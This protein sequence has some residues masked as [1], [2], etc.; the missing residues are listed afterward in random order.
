MRAV[1]TV[2]LIA[3][4]GC[5]GAS[6]SNP[7]PPPPE[8]SPA[9]QAIADGSNRFALDLY[10]RLRDRPGNLF[11][12]PYSVHAALA[13]T[14]DGAN[15][16]TRDQMVNVLHLP[17]GRDR[18]LVAGDLG[19]YYSAGEK[20]YELAV[21][22]ALW[23]QK[24]F[25]WRP[26]FLTRQRERFGAGFNEADFKADPEA[27]R[28]RINGWVAEKTRDK[29]KD[30]L[31]PGVVTPQTTMVLT[32]A[33]YFKGQWAERFD[34][35]KTR[36]GEFRLADGKTVTAPLMHNSGT[37]RHGDVEGTQVLEMPYQGGDLSMVVILPEK[38]DGLPALE[39][40]LTPEQLMKWIIT[41]REEKNFDVTLPR[42]KVT[43]DAT[44]NDPLK[45]LGTTE[46]FGGGAD[47]SGMAES[48][49]GAISA[50]VHKAFVDVNEEGT[51]AAAAT[52]V[53]AALPAPPPRHFRADRPFLFLIRDARHG[54][55]LFLGRLTDPTK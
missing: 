47:F 53:A 28:V 18:T 36:D 43:W 38:P 13:M 12:S 50:V 19:R 8:W 35:S 41:T 45:A 30:L 55:I 9:M 34:K 42:F 26:E 24:G 52:G 4:A 7:V 31:Q 33:I 48:S 51:E 10:G 46:A 1:V 22:N 39:R 32:N 25:P 27:E 11:F 40:R 16:P 23:G 5:R 37:Y 44:L 3:L 2:S 29:I 17:D 54:T 20:P 49:P 21:A 15:G 14:A 6:T